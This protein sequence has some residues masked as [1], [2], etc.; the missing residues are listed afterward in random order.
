MVDGFENL[1]GGQATT[2]RLW[3]WTIDLSAGTVTEEQLD[4]VA[5]D[6]PRVNDRLV[7]LP[8][9]WAY[10][11]SLDDA[12]ASLT[13]GSDLYKYDLLTGARAT[14]D[15]GKASHLGEPIFVPRDGATEEDD[16][17]VMALCHDEALDESRLVIINAQDFDGDPQAEVMMPRRVPYGAHGNWMPLT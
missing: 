9:R 8:A 17:W 6:F 1:Y 16:G 5:T 10:T 3:R 14:C 11:A 7:G 2:G 4:D 13:L 12:A 15:F